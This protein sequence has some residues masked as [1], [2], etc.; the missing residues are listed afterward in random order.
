MADEAGLAPEDRYC[1]LVMKGGITSGVV[2]P[3]AILK[4]AN[5]YRFKNI[6][7]TS[8]GAIAAVVTAAAEYFRR[9]HHGSLAG[10]ERLAQLPRIS[11]RKTARPKRNCC[12]SFSR[13]RRVDGCSA[14]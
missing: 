2:Y 10:F 5:H 11:G 3:P 4:L 14:S 8:A 12:G 9:H 6:G 13:T 1:D 7:G